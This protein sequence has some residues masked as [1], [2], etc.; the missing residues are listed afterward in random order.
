MGVHRKLES[1]F[2]EFVSGLM[3][4]FAVGGGGGKVGVGCQVVEFCSS[5][6]RA[7]GHG[8]LL[9]CSMQTPEH[10]KGFIGARK[11]RELPRKRTKLQAQQNKE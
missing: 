4:S 2:A 7:L 1:L 9:A 11:E 6:V 5:I 8:V 10:G 3:I